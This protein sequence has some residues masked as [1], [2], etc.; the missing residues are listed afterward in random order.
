MDFKCYLCF[1]EFSEV[2]EMIS[3]L[4]KDHKLV[5]H[6]DRIPCLVN[7][8]NNRLCGRSYLTLNALRKHRKSCVSDKKVK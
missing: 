3:H 6:S 8:E 2:A 4:K 7:F 5:D 1:K